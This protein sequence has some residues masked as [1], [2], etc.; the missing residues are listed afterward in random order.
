MIRVFRPLQLGINQR[1]LEQN[2]KFYFTVSATIGINLQAGTALLEFDYLKDTLACMDTSTLPD[3]G[4]SKPCGEFLVS[5]SFFSPGQRD[6][7]S[8]NVK[9][10]LGEQE[11]ELIIFGPRQWQHSI[12]SPPETIT[13]L[14]IDFKYAFGGEG[15]KNNPHGIGYKDNLLPCIED[16]DQLVLSPSERPGPAG[17]SV[18]DPTWPQRMKFQGKYNKKYLKK[19]F[20]GYPEDFDWRY[21]MCAPKDQWI[22]GYY[23]GDEPFEI[24]NMHPDIPVI[25]GD[26]PNLYPR[27]FLLHTLNGVEPEFSELPMN[28]DTI[29]FFPEKLLALLIWRGVTEVADDEADQISHVLAAYEDRAHPPRSYEYY[30]HAF[31]RRLSSDDP[32]LNNLN[33]DDLVPVG[34]KCAMELLQEQV[35]ADGGKSAFARNIGAKVTSLKKKADEKIEEAL[36]QAGKGLKSGNDPDGAKIDLRKMLKE[37]SEAKP[38]PDVEVLNQTLESILP[39]ITV[40]DPE[41]L[42]LKK[43]SFD[44]I[45]Q[46]TNTTKAFSEKKEKQA[47]TQAKKR[48]EKLKESIMI[49]PYYILLFVTILS[50]KINYFLIFFRIFPAEY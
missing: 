12:S 2:R 4:M 48:L 40:G 26:L 41:K 23:E 8:G 44:K 13:T 16:P 20:P 32:F 3:P 11:K 24:H 21:F 1:M 6:V 36:Q 17:F 22:E 27:C 19:Y 46:I 15:Y 35:F 38:D 28:L 18:K 5:G 14:P 10:K 33:T 45:S 30:R 7:T 31:E 39:G 43:F 49:S 25:Q 42:E 50:W 29:W 34:A 37:R 47:K 9:I